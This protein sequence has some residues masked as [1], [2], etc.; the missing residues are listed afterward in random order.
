M[1]TARTSQDIEGPLYI[2]KIKNSDTFKSKEI[3]YAIVHKGNE[4]FGLMNFRNIAEDEGK[5]VIVQTI[6][7]G[8]D[9]QWDQC[10][11]EAGDL[12]PKGNPALYV[13]RVYTF[14]EIGN[15]AYDLKLFKKEDGLNTLKRR[16]KSATSSAVMRK[17]IE[18]APKG[19]S[20]STIVD[21]VHAQAAAFKKS[22]EALGR[23]LTTRVKVLFLRHN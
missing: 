14:I 12:K 22:H 1:E 15:I 16:S 10:L 5:G 20:L 9:T 8:K 13:D 6:N 11:L 7:G 21:K 18:E 23:A 17:V 4:N 2:L 3:L 19:A